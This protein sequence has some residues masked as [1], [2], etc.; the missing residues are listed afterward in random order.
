M[1]RP[2]VTCVV[3]G[4][5]LR[6]LGDGSFADGRLITRTTSV[7]PLSSN[8]PASSNYSYGGGKFGRSEHVI[9]V[10]GVCAAKELR[11]DQEI[12]ER[13]VSLISSQVSE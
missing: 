12:A 13:A 2:T 5:V 6:R 10:C 4:D 11:A 7:E 3:C 8:W 9:A 1:G